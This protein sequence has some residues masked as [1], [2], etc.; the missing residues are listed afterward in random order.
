MSAA[1]RFAA[2][3]ASAAAVAGF[4]GPVHA[5]KVVDSIKQKGAVTCG[6]HTGRA[7][8]ALADSNGTSSSFLI[9]SNLL[10]SGHPAGHSP[11][12]C[13]TRYSN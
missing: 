12:V 10:Q 13:Q 4:T 11:P 1:F 6:V 9:C 5:G 7:G 2:V 8:F 3:C